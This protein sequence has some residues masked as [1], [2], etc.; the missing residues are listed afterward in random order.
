MAE[1]ACADYLAA[2]VLTESQPVTY[3]LLS[4]ALKVD[5]HAAKQM[6]SAFHEQQ[7]ARKANSVHATY[8]LTGTKRPP[9]RA[10]GTGAGDGP[11]VSMRSSPFMSSMP[12]PEEAAD[13]PVPRTAMVLVREEELAGAWAT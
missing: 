2:R 1:E 6:L 13:E 11:D 7:N 10:N 8:L 9:A 3:R 12:E 4:R 5:A